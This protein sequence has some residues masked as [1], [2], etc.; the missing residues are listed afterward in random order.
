M[1]K[2]WVL[3]AFVM[4]FFACAK[5]DEYPVPDSLIERDVMVNVL[6]D[7]SLFQAKVNH[8]RDPKLNKNVPAFLKQKY[9]IDSLQFVQN[10]RYYAS[11]IDEYQ[12]MYN[13]IYARVKNEIA[14]TNAIKE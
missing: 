3:V 11:R 2:S 8:N 5:K 4:V 13:E 7:L 14:T 12:K 10:N 9:G 1:M 6:Y